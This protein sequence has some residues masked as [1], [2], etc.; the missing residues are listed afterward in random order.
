[1]LYYYRYCVQLFFERP[2]HFLDLYLFLGGR[3]ILFSVYV[4]VNTSTEVKSIMLTTVTQD[5]WDPL[6]G[7]D[8]YSNYLIVHRTPLELRSVMHCLHSGIGD[9]RL[10]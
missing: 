3:D 1:M 7:A 4:C 10:G 5:S 6:T 8:L 9:S 2:Q